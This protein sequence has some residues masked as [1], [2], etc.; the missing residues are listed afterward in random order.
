MGLALSIVTPAAAGRHQ[1]INAVLNRLELNAE[2]NPAQRFEFILVDNSVDQEYLDL[3]CSSTWSFP[4][5]Y[6]F[7]PSADD[8]LNPALARNIG[9]RVAEGEVFTMIDADHWVHEDFIVGAIES[10]KVRSCLNIGFM[11][12]TSE[13]GR[14]KGTKGP[15][16]PWPYRIMWAIASRTGN[17]RFLLIRWL[18]QRLIATSRTLSFSK[19]MELTGINGPQPW[20][21]VWLLSY[22]AR[23]FFQIGGY[24][25]LYLRGY[26]R[27]DDD[28]FVRLKRI[29][30]VQNTSM[31]FSGVH[32]WHPQSARDSSAGNANKAYFEEISAK[33]PIRN[34]GHEWGKFIDGAFSILDEQKRGFLEHEQWIAD[35]FIDGK[36]RP[37]YCQSSPWDD[38]VH[39]KSSLSKPFALNYTPPSG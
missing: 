30:P 5:K 18:N 17:N 15:I 1:R 31:A 29:L 21:K 3:A 28:L 11:I 32:L 23:T 16:R 36:E 35:K 19:C 26:G 38:V 2:R 27:E 6:I 4:I 39:L 24:D 13:R 22:P 20:N 34:R 7:L 33:D 12:D 25:E 10:Q 37:Q 8:Y 14:F 9:F